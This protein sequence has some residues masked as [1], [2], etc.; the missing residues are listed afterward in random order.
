M[1]KK[2]VLVGDNFISSSMMQSRSQRL[3]EAGYELEFLDWM[4]E[5]R[6]RLSN[7]NLN[8]EKHGPEA[9]DPP[10]D[11][12]E[13]VSDASLLLVHFCPVSASIIEAANNLEAIGVARGG[14]ENIDE[15]AATQREI[16]IVHIV[17]RNKNAV[18]EFTIGMILSEMRN[19]ARSD[20]Y[21]RQGGW[22]NMLV[23]PDKCVELSHKTVGLI[24]LGAIGEILTQLLQGFNLRVLVYDPYV[25]KNTI[26]G[27]GGESVNLDTLLRESDVVSLHARLTEETK[28]LMGHQQIG[29]MKPTAY[30]V[31]TARAGLIDRT[32]LITALR[33]K[34]IAGAAL[35]VFWSEPVTAD[36][37]LLELDNLTVTSHLAGTT[38][39]AL[40]NSVD[41]LI[42]AALD[43]VKN[44]ATHWVINPEVLS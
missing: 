33:D 41:L 12:K 38:I 9:E 26:Q 40:Y 2:A 13:K 36:N 29:L 30:L 10:P 4:A 32:A 16:P 39:E 28:G 23:D 22:Y 21:M 14:W 24:G 37:E 35:D 44:G 25:E 6:Q 31:N 17:G 18:A 8:V 27:L 7:R 20:C 42:D 34:R 3:A 43:F 5:D 15:A 19:I 11:L 1:S